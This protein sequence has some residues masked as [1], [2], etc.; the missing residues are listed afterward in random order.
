VRIVF[1][2]A[3]AVVMSHHM[4]Y[5]FPE[6][7]GYWLNIWAAARGLDVRFEV[8][9]AGRESIG[10]IDIEAIVREEVVPLRP[11]L[12]I[13]YED[14]NQF[15]LK[16]LVPDLPADRPPQLADVPPG[17]LALWMR[18]AQR[19]SALARRVEAATGLLARPANATVNQ[20][21]D[22]LASG[23]EWPKPPYTLVWPAGL[24]ERDPDLARPELPVRLSVILRDLDRIRARSRAGR[25]RAGTRL[26]PMA[27]A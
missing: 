1:V 7:V 15:N 21:A 20:T 19:Y 11:D 26:L 5:S 9:N 14:A 24:D 18:V 16:S 2:G 27:G 4:P 8:M 10:S 22:G 6:F 12:V 13:Y 17:Q 3:S 25:R 23:V